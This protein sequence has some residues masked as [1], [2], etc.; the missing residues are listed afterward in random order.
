VIA[1]RAARIAAIAAAFALLALAA[2]CGGAFG[3]DDGPR[4]VVFTERICIGQ[5]LYRMRLNERHRV[6]IDNSNPSPNQDSLRVR[7]ERVPLIVDGDVPENST[8]G[9]LSTISIAAA[10][11]EETSVVVIPRRTGVYSIS[12]S[13]FQ[14]GDANVF[15]ARLEITED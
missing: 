8:I 4:E 14:Q 6:V 3:G 15:D 7:L 10:A 11:N 5:G 1:A 2:A 12:C 9:E 13:W